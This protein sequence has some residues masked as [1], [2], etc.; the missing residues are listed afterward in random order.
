LGVSLAAL[1]IAAARH[2]SGARARAYEEGARRE[3]ALARSR[4]YVSELA[5]RVTKLPADPALLGEIE[6][7]YFE[8]AGRGR[9]HV[10]AMAREGEFLF[11]VPGVRAIVKSLAVEWACYG[12]RLNAVAPGPFPTE[13]AFSRL[14]PGSELERQ[15]REPVPMGWFGEHDE[16]TS[17][18][19]YL[20][21]DA[22]P[23]QT[24]DEVTIDGAR[25]SSP[26]SSSPASP[27]WTGIGRG[28]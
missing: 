25:R 16:L 26:A 23:Y 1:A 19:A 8:E 2:T 6:A 11:S 21:S 14:M 9:V 3:A 27:A 28:K 22:S 17:L 10:W 13:C 4:K 12:I 20:L 7:R 24:G 18:V 15:A 5:R